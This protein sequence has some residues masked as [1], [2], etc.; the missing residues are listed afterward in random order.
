M[1]RS[2]EIFGGGAPDDIVYGILEKA[3]PPRERG[4]MAKLV[5]SIGLGAGDIVLDAGGYS[6][7]HGFELVKRFGCQLVVMDIVEDGL[8]G[9]RNQAL[10]MGLQPLPMFVR[11]DVQAMPLRDSS[12]DLIWACDMLGCVEPDAFFRECSR[13]LRTAGRVIVQAVYMTER[14]EGAERQRFFD[15]N[16]SSPGSERELVESA[17]DAAGLSVVQA[18]DVGSEEW[19]HRLQ[20]GEQRIREDLLTLSRLLRHEDEVRSAVGDKWFQHYL[21]RHEWASHFLHGK[22]GTVLYVLGRR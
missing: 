18:E 20:Q 6:G 8:R 9:G 13:V 21:A 15:G 2:L 10:E 1:R 22:L 11:G 4:L 17:I 19:E 7:H 3:P 16:P 5:E 12:I 14:L